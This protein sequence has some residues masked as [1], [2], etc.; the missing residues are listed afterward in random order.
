MKPAVRALALV[1]MAGTLCAASV[2]AE[3]SAT[4]NRDKNAN[5]MRVVVDPETGEVRAPTSDE[6]QALI[7]AE[8]AA[9][10]AERSTFA[11]A[12]ATA[13]TAPDVMP[14][15]KTVTR[16]KNGMVSIRLGQESL[17]LIKAETDA[18]GR[19]R[20]VHTNETSSVAPAQEK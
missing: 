17:S 12:A 11:R 13:A 8:Q 14:E 7:Q 6:L 3:E 15:A 1:A 2:F 10:A 20:A 18:Q 4:P 9:R 5:A 19:V 16:H